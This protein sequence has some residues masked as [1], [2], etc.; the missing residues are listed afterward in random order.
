V[1]EFE[2]DVRATDSVDNSVDVECN[3]ESGTEFSEGT[4]TVSCTA[5]DEAGNS[6]TEDFQ[7]RVTLETAPPENEEPE[8]TVPTEA[9]TIEATSA[10]GAT[11]SFS[12]QVSASDSED[13]SITPDCSPT[14]GSLF[15]LGETEVT[16][17]ATDSEG[18]EA[19]SSFTVTVQ[20]TT[21]PV[22]TLSSS[23]IQEVATDPGGI[24]VDYS[25]MI[26]ASDAVDGAITPNCSPASGAL[27]PVGTTE[28]TCKA[29]D[30][31]GNEATALLSAVVVMEGTNLPPELNIPAL[32]ISVVAAADASGALVDFG[33]QVT[34][35]D[36]EDG[37]ITPN[38]SPASGTMFSV[39]NA[40]VTCTATDSD[41]AVTR[42]VFPVMVTK[43]A[44]EGTG[45][46]VTGPTTSGSTGGGFTF[47]S[48]MIP[49]VAAVAVGGAVGAIVIAK[50]K[51]KEDI[52]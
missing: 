27:M 33:D 40:T 42:K 45:P 13:G 24:V 2:D 12:E 4:V 18:A 20:D 3:P 47:E 26:S 48:A 38:C 6:A 19:E 36:R 35:N 29:I 49:I 34:A 51:K 37:A 22:I 21:P 11:V 41:G 9:L 1:I 32:P 43:S 39:G 28:I 46:T 25:G 16:C 44:T 7:V 30:R 14:S 23:D 8:I 52:P 17:V 15:A 5:T 31:S 50:R 10:A